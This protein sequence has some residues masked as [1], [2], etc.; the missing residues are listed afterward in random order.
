MSRVY[1]FSA[2]PAMLPTEVLKKASE[3][4]LDW[5]GSGT[6][7]MEIST[8]SRNWTLTVGPDRVTSCQVLRYLWE[9]FCQTL[10][11]LWPR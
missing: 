10:I 5:G 1:N 4:M 7:V 2:G 3:E 11:F 6:S 8:G 9:I